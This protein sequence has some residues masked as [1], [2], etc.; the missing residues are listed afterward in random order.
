MNSTQER[1]L[2]LDLA[3][4]P[5]DLQRRTLDELAAVMSQV[6]HAGRQ[7]DLSLAGADRVRLSILKKAFSGRLVAQDPKDEPASVLLER[8]RAGNES[9]NKKTNR[10]DAA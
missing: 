9:N 3:I 4:P 10:K 1:F 5:L 6:D 7:I 8:V 2:D